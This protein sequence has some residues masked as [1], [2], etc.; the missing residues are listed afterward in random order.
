MRAP[1]QRLVSC[2]AAPLA[3]QMDRRCEQCLI[4]LVFVEPEHVPQIR[5]VSNGIWQ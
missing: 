1:V 5:C 2:S 3:P 4:M